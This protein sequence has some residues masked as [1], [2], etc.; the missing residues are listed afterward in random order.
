[1]ALQIKD[2]LRLG[3]LFLFGLVLL[4]AALGIGFVY[5][6]QQ[7]SGAIL[8]DNY[9]SLVY[10]REMQRVVDGL[11]EGHPGNARR[12][13]ARRVDPEP[14][15]ENLRLEEANITEVGEGEAVRRVRTAWEQFRRDSSRAH[16]PVL[17][18]GL[19]RI[20]DVNMEAI[21][22]K[23]D[24]AARS[25]ETATLVIGILGTLCV[26]IAF[27]FA[28]NFPSYIAE[29]LRQLTAGIRSVANR[30]YQTRMHVKTKDEFSEVAAAFNGMVDKLDEYENS[31]LAKILFEKRRIE[32]IIANLRDA[33][34]GLDDKN[35]V[36]FANPVALN[37][38][39]LNEADLVGRYAPDVA[40]KN[41]LFRTLLNG[42]DGS[43][44]LKIYADDRE[45]FFVREAFDVEAEEE[46]PIR[47]PDGTQNG[48]QKLNPPRKTR[49]G[50][51]ILLKNVTHYHDLDAAKTAF[52]ATVSHE[53]KTPIS[54]IKMSLKLLQDERVGALN[55][56]QQKLLRLV[57]D[58]AGRLLRI[59]GELLDL[60][61][62]ETGTIQL[63]AE[64]VVVADL[65]DYALQAVRVPAEQRGVTFNSPLPADLPAVLA[66]REKTT[67]V[68][69]N[70]L[71]NAIR[72]SP[73]KGTVDVEAKLTPEGVEVSVRDRGKGVAPEFR[74]KVFQ[75]YFRVPGAGS[76]GG[77]GLGLAISKEFIEAQN[78]QIGVESAGPNQGSRFF[79]RLPVAN[80]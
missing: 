28:I 50:Q 78:G 70:F 60:S 29:P 58:D 16:L 13:N 71:T 12:G 37:L 68:L 23:N 22:R 34:V 66:D 75:R 63:K 27:S 52:I 44:E 30:N 79:F 7:D 57:E 56:E 46:T 17:R 21:V 41:D 31:N 72:H 67:W 15:A 40:L 74:E 54:G 4:L 55:G 14:F 69:I 43:R 1:M 36:L 62:V 64:P 35:L 61:Q 3:L 32:T 65:L 11:D 2:K 42:N 51:V 33:V 47:L 5:R 10:V 80:G 73:E 24:A 19:Y 45:S 76:G 18:Q 20:L 9:R 38:L 25:A 53:L 59:T 8:K 39:N 49:I 6:L 77:T 48:I 26:L